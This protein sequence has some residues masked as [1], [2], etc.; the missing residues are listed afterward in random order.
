MVAVEPWAADMAWGM[1]GGMGG[2]ACWMAGGSRRFEGVAECL[3]PTRP[4]ITC[5]GSSAIVGVTA[6]VPFKNS[7]TNTTSIGHAFR[8]D[9]RIALTT[10]STVERVDIT[11]DLQQA[12]GDSSNTL[13]T[14]EHNRR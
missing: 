4:K 10:F 14:R 12:E 5:G 1:A 8:Y 13:S 11:D 3:L 2:M 9:M 6:L 7:L